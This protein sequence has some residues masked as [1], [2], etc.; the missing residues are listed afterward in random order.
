MSYKL[1]FYYS[2]V[3]YVYAE[4]NY[5]YCYYY[6]F[7][8]FFYLFFTCSKHLNGITVSKKI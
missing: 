1:Y 3:Q 2:S 5:C 8:L 6:Y 7:F 4:Y